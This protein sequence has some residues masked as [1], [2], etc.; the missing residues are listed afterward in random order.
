[1]RHDRQVE[2][3]RRLRGPDAPRPG[4]LGSASVHNPAGAYTSVERFG[5]ELRVLFGGLPQLAALSCDVGAPGSYLTTTAGRVPVAVVRQA[6]GEVRAFV[7]VCRHRGATLLSPSQG[8]ELRKITCPYH[9]WTYGLDGCLRSFPGA[10]AGFDDVDKTTHGLLELPVAEAYGLIFVRSDPNGAPFTVDDALQGAETELA[11]FGLGRYVHIE[12]RS[13]EW[14]M[15][16]KLVMDT[17]TE[18][19]HIPWLHKDSIAPY[20]LFDRWI[21]DSY[22]PHPRMIGTRKSVM[23][24][25]AKPSEDEWDLLPHGTI[26]YLLL[27]NAVLV[28]QVDHLELWRLTPLAVDR[29]LA[30]TSVYAP[31]APASE[32]ARGYFVKNLDLLLGVTDNEDFPAQERVQRNLASGRL[33]EV[34]YG[35]MEPALVHYHAAIN[36]LLDDAGEL[37]V[38]T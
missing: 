29:T 17:F 3:L 4:P 9:A 2:L 19:Y 33:A 1:V 24:E 25:F 31:S 11:D 10:E 26:Q 18:P 16:W 21:Y 14:Q 38:D 20:Y 13:H 6:D 32:R 34:V 28:H 5:A 35:K 37:N 27:P 36:Q 15:N 30:V 7:N 12:T 23:D 22:G 8:E